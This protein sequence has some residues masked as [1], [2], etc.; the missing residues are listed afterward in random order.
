[1]SDRD[2]RISENESL[3]RAVNEQI[4]GVTRTFAVM[5]QT[6]HVVCE[7]GQ[8]DCIERFMMTVPAY[9]RVRADPALFAVRPGHELPDMEDVVDTHGDYVVIRKHDGEPAERAREL[10]PRDS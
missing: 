8:P 7:C 5:T 1:M 9:E 10:D 4:E 6:M 2:R 3:F